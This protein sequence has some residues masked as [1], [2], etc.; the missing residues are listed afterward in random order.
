MALWLYGSMALWL[1]GSDVVAHYLWKGEKICLSLSIS[2]NVVM[3][4]I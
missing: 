3:L 4:F 1:Y 2:L